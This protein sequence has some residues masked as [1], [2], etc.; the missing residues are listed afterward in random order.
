MISGALISLRPNRDSNPTGWMSVGNKDEIY[1]HS[2]EV[3][4]MCRLALLAFVR[5]VAFALSDHNHLVSQFS[6]E[7]D[8]AV[9]A[10]PVRR[11]SR[12]PVKW[13]R[14]SCITPI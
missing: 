4:R 13:H 9:D 14:R 2:G 7:R 3:F 12:P 10:R 11:R 8:G 6:D 1:E 5:S